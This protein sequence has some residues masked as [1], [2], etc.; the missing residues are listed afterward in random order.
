MGIDTLAVALTFIVDGG[1]IAANFVK[2]LTA[3]KSYNTHGISTVRVAL[4]SLSYCSAL[5]LIHC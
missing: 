2:A 1:S 3:I 5:R 4:S